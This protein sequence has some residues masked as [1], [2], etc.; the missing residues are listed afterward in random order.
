MM[1]AAYVAFATKLDMDGNTATIT[2]DIGGG[3]EV[4]EVQTPFVL[5]AAK[6]VAEQRIPNMRGIMAAR[7]KPLAVVAAAD[8]E[9]RTSIANY[10]LPPAKSAVKMIDAD[11][12]EE[13][14]DL[15]H[16]EAK[17]I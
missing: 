4:V 15:L 5:S 9:E 6:G 14:V 8:T 2:R 12:V 10:E 13:L 7:T 3:S 1:D 11:N 16:N 17:M